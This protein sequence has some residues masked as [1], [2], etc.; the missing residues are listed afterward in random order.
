MHDALKNSG[1]QVPDLPA[2]WNILCGLAGLAAEEILRGKDS[3]AEL[4]KSDIE[5]L[6]EALET[7]IQ[8][9]EG[10]FLFVRGVVL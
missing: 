6:A 4:K 1:F 9:G 10:L 3:D 2:N 5:L 7:T 8:G